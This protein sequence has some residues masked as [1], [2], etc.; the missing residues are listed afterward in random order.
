MIKRDNESD[1][2]VKYDAF[3]RDYKISKKDLHKERIQRSYFFYAV[4]GLVYDIISGIDVA[5]KKYR[6]ELQK[7]K[8]T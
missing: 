5:A 4:K 3:D 8:K 1:E 7:L 2:G 6:E